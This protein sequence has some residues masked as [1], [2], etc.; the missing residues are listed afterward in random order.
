MKWA[1]LLVDAHG[2][3]HVLRGTWRRIAAHIPEV[4]AGVANLRG[5]IKGA[6]P[7]P[8]PSVLQIRH[9]D[10]DAVARASQQRVDE[11]LSYSVYRYRVRALRHAS[12]ATHAASRQSALRTA[13]VGGSRSPRFGVGCGGLGVSCGGLGVSC[14]GFGVGCGGLG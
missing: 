3:L 6:R 7:A 14:G 10:V 11:I 2:A 5:R 1:H 12:R 4:L 13:Q 9:P 8:T